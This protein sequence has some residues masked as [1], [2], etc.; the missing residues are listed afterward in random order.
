MRPFT[1]KKIHFGGS[2]GEVSASGLGRDA[3]VLGSS[4]T[5]G[6][7]PAQ[8]EVG[9]SLSPL[10]LWLILSLSQINK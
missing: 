6:E 5:L 3:R 2:V 7:I 8:R 10:M 1:I 4:P 9:F